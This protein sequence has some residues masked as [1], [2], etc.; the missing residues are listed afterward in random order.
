MLS[1]SLLVQLD[2]KIVLELNKVVNSKER[3]FIGKDF[4]FEGLFKL[5]IISPSQ[6]NENSINFLH[7]VLNSEFVKHGMEDWVI[8]ILYQSKKM[9][10]LNLIPKFNVK[11]NSKYEVC[12][13]SKQLSYKTF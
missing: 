1:D 12:V 10:N 2:F 11:H 5:N 8:S 7:L 3:V 4:V 6:I 13:Q 9:S